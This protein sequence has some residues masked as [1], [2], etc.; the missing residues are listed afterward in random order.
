MSVDYSNQDISGLNLSNQNLTGG[1]F[2]NTNATNVNFTNAIIT[3]AVFKNT[4]ITGA[5]IN[6]LT[7]SELQKG[8]LL[9]RAANHTNP[10]VN[11]LTSL[12]LAN[13]RVI[14]PAISP[15]MLNMI[16]TVTVKIPLSAGNYTIPVTP[17]INQL[18]CIFVAT[19]Q[20]I[21]ITSSSNGGTTRT[22]RS[23]GTVI[24]D[25]DNANSTL[26]FLKIGLIPYRMSVGNGDGVISMIP[27]D[28]NVYQVSS[29]GLGDIMS[30]NLGP[31]GPTGPT[32]AVGS[33]GPTG[34]VG[35][36]GPTGAVGST[37]PTGAVGSTGPTGAVGSTGPTGA[38]GSTGPTGVV[39]STGPTGAVGSTGPTG[40]VGST[41]PTGAVGSTG[42]V[43]AV[44]AVGPTGAVG[45]TGSTGPIGRSIGGGLAYIIVNPT[46]ATVTT[47]SFTPITNLTMSPTY[48]SAP[49]R[50]VT[51]SSYAVNT[52]YQLVSVA[53]SIPKEANTV[54]SGIYELNQFVNFTA[55]ISVPASLYAKLYF[56]STVDASNR[57]INRTY[58]SPGGSDYIATLFTEFISV[59]NNDI[60]LVLDS[61]TFPS[62]Y[63]NSG[64][65]SP[66]MECAIV[67]QSGTVIY[68]F[69]TIA[70]TNNTEVN[71][72]F[73]ASPS[74][75]ITVTSN[76]TAFRFRLRN[77]ATQ[78]TP[79]IGQPAALNTNNLSYSLTGSSI[80]MLL[81]DGMN[82]PTALTSSITA[83]YTL[84]L[85][86]PSTPFTI[87]QFTTPNI[88]LE[89][90]FIQPTGA[91]T[92]NSVQLQFNDNGLSNFRTSIAAVSTTPTLSQ[93]LAAGNSA[94]TTALNMNSQNI[95]N[96][97]TITAVTVTPT[98]ITDW[99]VKS[100]TAGSGITATNNGSGTW[101]VTN[102]GVLTT[103]SIDQVLYVGNVATNQ[104]LSGLNALTATTVNATNIPNWNVKQITAGTGVGVSN[105]S[106]NYTI[107]AST[108]NLSSVM[109]VG[110]SVGSTVLNMNNQN[111]TSV[112]A[113]TAATVNATSIPNW[114]VKQI[115]AGTGVSVTDISGNYTI[116]APISASTFFTEISLT[117]NTNLSLPTT[118]DLFKYDYEM[119][120]TFN[121]VLSNKW[122]YLRFNQDAG[123]IAFTE[124]IFYNPNATNGTTSV[125]V[126]N[127]NQVGGSYSYWLN[128]GSVSSGT[129]TMKATYR[130]SAISA[131]QFVVYLMSSQPAVLPSANSVSDTTL[132]YATKIFYR[133][134]TNNVSRWCPSHMT[135]HCGASDFTNGR[136]LM[137][138]VIKSSSNL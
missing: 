26:N 101:T 6:T 19:N 117:P 58:P 32:G 49:V 72:V 106:G 111:I 136:C 25:V 8:H 24:Q 84:S 13:F 88:T 73:T 110:N 46:T 12:T 119:D 17:V 70:F 120:F 134:S 16:Q 94:G 85:P 115:T 125:A 77:L 121:D 14:Q 100:L 86:L 76:I 124:T 71:R 4:L 93:V 45:S 37:G 96:C 81:H 51:L 79:S 137:S 113:I 89:Q 20:N 116:S 39:G 30:L 27:I 104:N 47:P 42:A 130:I 44:G 55:S 61:I 103:P 131:E 60:R 41:G 31:I 57:L 126:Y 98:N 135:I 133:Y 75:T 50:T 43:G 23:T 83:V 53:G 11:N 128:A 34:A 54:L 64:T 52:N 82:T 102:T 127:S 109:A 18:I 108:P 91:T 29:S 1:N 132:V 90:W 123:F 87:A 35:S 36:T 7:F 69:P 66:T 99:N 40:A 107:T 48:T 21:I 95:T 92:N 3:N 9:L 67:N 2:T 118:M 112:N 65:P 114:N 122:F 59:P 105:T 129:M 10:S 28:L 62:V 68:T 97:N 80:R 5:I 63:A 33:T 74:A 15:D 138:Q 56:T 78:G 22:I 38:V